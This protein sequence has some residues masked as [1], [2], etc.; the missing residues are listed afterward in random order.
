[1]KKKPGMSHKPCSHAGVRCVIKFEL[2][3]HKVISL[4]LLHL[5]IDNPGRGP[6]LIR[7]FRLT[8]K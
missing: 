3:G 5:V 4:D 7:T 8:D 6:I 2:A 1:M